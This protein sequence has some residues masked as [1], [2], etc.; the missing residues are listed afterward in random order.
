MKISVIGIAD[1]PMAFVAAETENG[2][3]GPA[4]L[5]AGINRPDVDRHGQSPERRDGRPYRSPERDDGRRDRP[6][7]WLKDCLAMA[8][9]RLSAAWQANAMH[10]ADDGI[11]CAAVADPR[12][13]LRT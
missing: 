5:I 6:I 2:L 11:A 12:G 9:R 3:T 7:A 13:Y 10:L 8:G 1:R 4:R